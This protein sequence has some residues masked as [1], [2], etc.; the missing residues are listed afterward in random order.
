MDDLLTL[1]A[2]ALEMLDQ[3]RKYFKTP[4]ESPDK[5]VVLEASKKVEGECRALA[6]S[7]SAIEDLDDAY[8]ALAK[9]IIELQ[10][11]QYTF[12]HAQRGTPER[13]VAFKKCR[14]E[15]EPNL[16][17]LCKGYLNLKKEPQQPTLF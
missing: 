13:N 6:I 16:R 3:Q 5:K 4:Y 17:R 14:D 8:P 1:S 12:F 9:R 11:W 7:A 10:D 2:K 15:L